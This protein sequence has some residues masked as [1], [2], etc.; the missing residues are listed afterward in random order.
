MIAVGGT[1]L[2][3][4]ADGSYAGETGWS[5]G[6]DSNPAYA[7][8]GGIS[9]Y[10]QEPSYQFGVQSTGYRTAPDV[11]F[12]ADPNTGVFEYDSFS[13][14][15]NASLAWLI[16][17]GTSL[18]TPCWAGLIALVDQGRARR[19]PRC[20]RWT[21][22]RRPDLRF[23]I[24]RSSDFH[25]NLGGT[26][27][28][29]NGPNSGITNPAVYN[30]VTGLGT[31]IANL[32]VPA[33][34]TY[35]SGITPIGSVTLPTPILQY[36]PT[37][38]VLLAT[39]TQGASTQ[40]AAAYSATVAWGDGATDT[41]AEANSAL[42]IVVT[43]QSIQVFGTHAFA[44]SGPLTVGIA[45]NGPG[46]F[47]YG[48]RHCRCCQQRLQRC[49]HRSIWH[50]LQSFDKVVLRLCSASRK[51]LRKHFRFFRHPSTGVDERG[52][53]NLRLG[54]YRLRHLQTYHHAG[55]RRRRVRPH[56]PIPGQS[57]LAPGQTL[58]YLPAVQRPQPCPVWLHSRW[59]F[60]IRSIINTGRDAGDRTLKA[61]LPK[62]S[63]Q[64]PGP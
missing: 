64:S 1:T 20:P 62:P 40:T 49:R 52:H 44:T 11:S 34:V 23:T 12:D 42:R 19:I 5:L 10:E 37:G 17:D 28:S 38:S 15:S 43:A 14:G 18:A 58:S 61:C 16:G 22:Q 46:V 3:L 55:Q 27:G 32:L 9:L 26:N 36:I 13:T 59:C 53:P 41:T 21:V 60:P 54:Y 50:D 56:S 35:H 63:D 31:P 2:S 33:L 4:N 39:F 29:N 25:H 45:I 7:S 8:G 47:R 51:H 24:C 48:L 30:E 6:S 57:P